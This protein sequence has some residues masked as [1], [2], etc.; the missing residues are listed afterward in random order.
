MQKSGH[1]S[2]FMQKVIIVIRS[3]PQGKVVSYGQV[4]VYV[5]VPRAARQ[6]G[7]TLRH[8]EET[9]SVPWWR[10][11]NNTG[12][13]SIQGNIH[14]DRLLQKKLLEQEGVTVHEDFTLD[15]EQYRFK[16]D[17][18]LLRAWELPE[19]YREFVLTKYGL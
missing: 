3:V 18:T 11:I 10:V 9:V 6:V 14:N 2:Q 7:W 12:R 15:I 13:I 8:M 1:V 17:K 19:T 16:A 4:A 5:G